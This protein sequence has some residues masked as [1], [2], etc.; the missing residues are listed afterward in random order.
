[1]SLFAITIA[2]EVEPQRLRFV[3]A[4]WQAAGLDGLCL[5]S[6]DV[7]DDLVEELAQGWRVR[8]V[9]PA[10][11]V[12]FSRS[13]WRNIAVRFA[14]A[15]SVIVV[16]TDC[17]ILDREHD[18]KR[19]TLE[20][21][22]TEEGRRFCYWPFTWGLEHETD[23][24]LRG[25][26]AAFEA[27]V[28]RGKG[29]AQPWSGLVAFHRKDLIEVS[30]NDDM[31][32]WGFEDHDL[33][34][35]AQEHGFA[36]VGMPDS[37]FAH[38]WHPS[39]PDRSKGN[40]FANGRIAMARSEQHRADPKMSLLRAYREIGMGMMPATILGYTNHSQ[41]GEPS[42]RAEIRVAF[43][44]VGWPALAELEQGR[45]PVPC[46]YTPVVGA[47]VTDFRG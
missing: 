37:H 26:Y 43:E 6:D 47:K 32:G 2:H 8:L 27:L 46:P 38:V 39:R 18:F 19:R 23:A 13:T 36:V 15:D 30:W 24:V 45:E 42:I 17:P 40:K 10:P 31:V 14:P 25:D 4:S 1:M 7:T 41:R 20:A 33:F 21:L 11:Q 5:V 35:R 34:A 44:D 12:S 29:S 22:G 9:R 3:A 16:D 28:D